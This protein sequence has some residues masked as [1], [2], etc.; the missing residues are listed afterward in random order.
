MDQLVCASLSHT[1]YWHEVGMLKVPAKYAVLYNNK[2]PGS[3]KEVKI[4][5]RSPGRD[6][7]ILSDRGRVDKTVRCSRWD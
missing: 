7:K 3:S 6:G 2:H 5:Y 1:H 4:L